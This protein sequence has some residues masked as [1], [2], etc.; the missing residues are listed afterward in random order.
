MT[1]SL[2]EAAS[3]DAVSCPV[4]SAAV[5]IIL[6]NT[7]HLWGVATYCFNP[8][9]IVIGQFNTH[10]LCSCLRTIKSCDATVFL[11]SQLHIQTQHMT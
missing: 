9:L 5:N 7:Q 3:T 11:R 4:I 10:L 1:P 8:L 2:L 6:I